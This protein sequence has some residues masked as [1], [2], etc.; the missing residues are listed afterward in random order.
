MPSEQLRFWLE[1]VASFAGIAALAAIALELQRARKADTRDFLFQTTEK[2][3]EIRKERIYLTSLNFSNL[4]EFLILR[5]D[6]EYGQAFVAVFN[7]WSLLVKTTRLNAV[8]QKIVFDEYGLAFMN[9]YEKFSEVQ[10]EFAKVSGFNWFEEL[11]WFADEYMRLFPGKVELLKK[12]NE[13]VEKVVSQ[14]S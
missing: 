11:D 1:L 13:Y 4:K 5:R 7:F 2:I 6:D 14:A 8:N 3:N 9:Y 12:Q 10:H